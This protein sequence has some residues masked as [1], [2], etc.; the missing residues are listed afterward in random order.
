MHDKLAAGEMPPKK[1]PATACDR[2]L[3][4]ATQFLRPNCTRPRWTGSTNGRVVVRRLNGTE[5]ENTIRDLLGTHV[6]LKD[7]L[8]ED[9]SAAGFDNV[10]SALDLS[11]DAP[12]A[13]PGG[14][15]EGGRCRSSRCTRRSRSA[16]GG[17]GREMTEKGPNFQQTLDRSCKLEGDALII[18]SK[19]PRYG[20]CAT[21]PV[22]RRAGT[23]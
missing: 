18:Y 12:A 17:P 14:G 11:A 22:P 3:Q 21:A 9:N 13:L 16:T 1:T 8:P 10:S 20:L 5:Y 19:L 6:R 23:G 4:S 7:M 15:G 2:T